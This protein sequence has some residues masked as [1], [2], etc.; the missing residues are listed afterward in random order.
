MKIQRISIIISNYFI[1]IQV[2]FVILKTYL[3]IPFCY[4]EYKTFIS[5]SY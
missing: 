5:F 4:R 1:T 3:K 2:K